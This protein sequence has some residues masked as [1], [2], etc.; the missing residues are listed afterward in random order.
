M[1]RCKWLADY[2]VFVDKVREYHKGRTEAELEEDI[3]KAIDY[4]IENNYLSEFFTSRRSEVLEVTKVDYTFE[5][6]M[7]LNYEEGREDGLREGET[8]G[9]LKGKAETIRELIKNEKWSAEKAMKSVGIPESEYDT[10]LK[11]L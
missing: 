11:M 3:S 2:M 1:K 9:K 6:R 7:K 8:S 5:R 10:Y 4:C